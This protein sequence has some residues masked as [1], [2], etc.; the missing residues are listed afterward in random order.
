M[1][2]MSEQ[3]PL[4]LFRASMPPSRRAD[5]QFGFFEGSIFIDFNLNEDDIIYL[6]KISFDGYG[7]DTLEDNLVVLN[8]ED[9]IEFVKA[10]RRQYLN[11]EVLAPL[12]RKTIIENQQ[13]LWRD[14]LQRYHL[15]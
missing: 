12:I 2:D 14:A 4:N 6:K 11:E 5:F 1:K 10:C 3:K 9:S 8:S 7:C 13:H 15:L